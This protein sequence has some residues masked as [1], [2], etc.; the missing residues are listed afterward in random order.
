[1]KPDEYYAQINNFLIKLNEKRKHF[2]I[3]SYLKKAK[4][5]IF[6][7]INDPKYRNNIYKVKKK[8]PD[9]TYDVEVDEGEV[10]RLEKKKLSPP[11]IMTSRSS[12]KKRRRSESPQKP[13]VKMR[14]T[15][16]KTNQ[17]IVSSPSSP[18]ATMFITNKKKKKKKY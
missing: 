7:S 18:T 13:P 11:Q 1:M 15:P 9:G 16:S 10:V 2:D 12:R 3:A 17:G 14:E 5:T 4:K 8:Y 6:V